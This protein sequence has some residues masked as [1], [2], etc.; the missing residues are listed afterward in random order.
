MKILELEIKNFK[1]HN[2]RSDSKSCSWFRMSNDFFD[3]PDFFAVSGDGQ[4]LWIYLL[5]QASK[6]MS[7]TVKINTQLVANALRISVEAVDFAILELIKTGSLSQKPVTLVSD[8]L[9]AEHLE[10][11]TLESCTLRTNERNVT[12]VTERT[13]EQATPKNPQGD[14]CRTVIVMLNSLCGSRYPVNDDYCALINSRKQDGYTLED[15]K[16]VISFRQATWSE[17]PKMREYL[18]PETLFGPKFY[19]YLEQSKRPVKGK[20]RATKHNPH[21]NPYLNDDGTVKE[22]AHGNP[23]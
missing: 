13:N 22:D 17:D 2:P 7:D 5:G 12:N 14:F 20:S 16:Q 1:K 4:R 8:N 15:F 10:N 18:R 3:D 21:G 11:V 6:R 9:P 19:T 23:A